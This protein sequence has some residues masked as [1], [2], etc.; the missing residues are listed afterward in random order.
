MSILA[1]IR[2]WT[3]EIG[4]YHVGSLYREDNFLLSWV[5]RKVLSKVRISDE[6]AQGLKS[7]SGPR[8]GASRCGGFP[9]PENRD[10][11]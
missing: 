11:V 6:M 7:L 9:V 2:S 5:V 10:V 4:V 3:T 1:T 8:I